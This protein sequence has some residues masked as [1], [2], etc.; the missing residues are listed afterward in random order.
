LPDGCRDT[1]RPDADTPDRRLR[2]VGSALLPRLEKIG[3]VIPT[4]FDTLDFAK[5]DLLAGGLDRIAPEIVINP[6][7]YTAVDQ[8]E[9]AL[10]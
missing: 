5:P 8:A 4:D 2:Q 3:T 6:A 7:A 9:D 1:S 10:D